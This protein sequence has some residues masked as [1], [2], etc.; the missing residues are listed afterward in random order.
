MA[1][2]EI[3]DITQKK[4]KKVG[5]SED[6]VRAILPQVR[7]YVSFWREYPDKLIDFLAGEASKF[8]LFFYQRVFLR[9]VIRHKYAYATFPRAYS[10]SFLSVLVLIIRCVLYPGAK[11]FVCSGGKSL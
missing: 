6:R 2:Q 8:S 7:E 9:A 1:L 4:N 5:L 3:L 10:K 11:L